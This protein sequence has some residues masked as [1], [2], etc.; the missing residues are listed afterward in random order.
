VS[1][2]PPP[3]P[4]PSFS[5][6]T[7]ITP[8]PPRLN[9]GAIAIGVAVGTAITMFVSGAV[10]FYLGIRLGMS[11]RTG[12]AAMVQDTLRQQLSEMT[13]LV[14]MGAVGL[15]FTVLG[16]YVTGRIARVRLVSHGVWMGVA[17]GGLGLLISFLTSSTAPLWFRLAGWVATI[18][19]G[20][21]GS[22][23]ARRRDPGMPA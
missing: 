6:Q 16:G 9:A 23:L 10:V 15:L 20:A 1:S 4:E 5:T 19:A 13:W 17:S 3:I 11:G 2:V 8:G 12:S 18:P 14:R 21:C 22:A 7:P